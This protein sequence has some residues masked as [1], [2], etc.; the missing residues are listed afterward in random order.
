MIEKDDKEDVV[1][2]DISVSYPV[3][4]LSILNQITL[5]KPSK[6]ISAKKKELMS[7]F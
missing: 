7:H 4:S 5:T 6:D 2:M 1:K 3:N